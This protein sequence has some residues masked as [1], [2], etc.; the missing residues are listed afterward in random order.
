[1][2]VKRYDKHVNEVGDG[3]FVTYSD[4]Q[5]LVVENAALVAASAE[6]QGWYKELLEVI[7]QVPGNL[8]LRRAIIGVVPNLMNQLEAE[9]QR[10]DKAHKY[11]S[12]RDTENES[13]MLTVGRLRIEIEAL[14]GDQVPVGLV[15]ERQGSGGFCLTQHGRRLNL[16]HGTALFAAPQ[17]PIVL[18]GISELI[19]ACDSTPAVRDVHVWDLAISEVKRLNTSL[20]SDKYAAGGI[21]KDGE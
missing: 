5:K 6:G 14:K 16:P 21:V 15:D 9:R 19:D 10:A 17:K 4:Y 11:G 8:D 1:M 20:F 2:T 7:K 18:P 13:L 3:E 12:E